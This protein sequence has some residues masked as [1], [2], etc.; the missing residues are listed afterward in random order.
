MEENEWAFCSLWASRRLA[1]NG[2]ARLLLN[3]ALVGDYF[4]NRASV[5]GCPDPIRSAGRAAQAC[6]REG[7][8]MCYLYDDMSGRL[9]RTGKIEGEAADTMFVLQ[10]PAGRG[11][12][13]ADDDRPPAAAAD[14]VEVRAADSEQARREWADVFCRSFGVQGWKAEVERIVAAA[15]PGFQEGN[16]GAAAATDTASATLAA[17]P[18]A[19][20][21]D[22]LLCYTARQQVNSTAVGCAALYTRAGDG[23]SGIYCLGVLPEHRGMGFAK[24]LVEEA[25]AVSFQKYGSG[26]AFLQSLAS[27]GSLSFYQKLGFTVAYTKKIY[28]LR[29]QQ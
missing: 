23:L 2:C 27:E 25:L 12:T 19:A 15:E 8:D 11:G 29:R 10:K 22:L 28:A 16:G 7:F 17:T 21:L 13:A 24:S 5:S 14:K 18:A 9:A 26:S 4:F 6:W 1:V 3:P 20:T